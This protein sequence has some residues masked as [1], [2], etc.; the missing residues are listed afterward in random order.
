M[1]PLALSVVCVCCSPTQG[2][3]WHSQ[4][5]LLLG[6]A[7]WAL[8]IAGCS[9]ASQGWSSRVARLCC[10]LG[11]CPDA[12]ARSACRTHTICVR[13]HPAQ[14]LSLLP[15]SS[16]CALCRRHH[17]Q[18]RRQGVVVVRNAGVA[19]S[20]QSLCCV[21]AQMAAYG[22]SC[23]GEVTALTP[24]GCCTSLLLA[25]PAGGHW[26]ALHAPSCTL[27]VAHLTS[28]LE[29]KLAARDSCWQSVVRWLRQGDNRQATARQAALQ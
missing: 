22:C 10:P 23:G 5:P 26:Q 28:Q 20:R 11:L 2:M 24:T 18:Q 14:L 12:H 7:C 8:G 27:V 1:R 4:L 17:Q 15:A 21:R 6:L 13:W 29:A 9:T 3:L 16:C 25:A 19:E